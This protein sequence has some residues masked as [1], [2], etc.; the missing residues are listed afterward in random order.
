MSFCCDIELGV[1]SV[2]SPA[3]L[4]HL[5]HYVLPMILGLSIRNI[6]CPM[7][8]NIYDQSCRYLVG[9]DPPGFFCWLL[10]SPIE[11]F[12]F[13]GWLDTRAI[14]LPREPDRTSDMVA[15][16]VDLLRNGVPWSLVLEIQIVPDPEM[17]GRILGHFAA[18]WKR[19]KPDMERGSRFHLGAA[20]INLTGR[21]NC[22]QHMHWAEA[23][24]TTH[25]G[26]RER[27]L[28]YESADELLNKVESGQWPRSLLLFI[29]FM[30][31]GD[32]PG[33]IDRW[34]ILAGAEPDSHLRSSYALIALL[35]ADRVQR[36]DLWEYKL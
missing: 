2:D 1:F 22:S 18:I 17:L 35:F 9:L 6:G 12:T 29:P 8:Q 30:I 33:N 27:N 25:L 13:R 24:L 5:T 10:K 23:E 4:S 16:L 21:G 19:V 36:K 31:G 34:M 20:V 3:L 26:V 14:S 11:A 15:Y 7:S 28:E 32:E